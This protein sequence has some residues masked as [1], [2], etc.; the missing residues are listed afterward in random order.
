VNPNRPWLG[1]EPTKED[2]E[3]IGDRLAA[4]TAAEVLASPARGSVTALV[5][6]SLQ[7]SGT[8]LYQV[9]YNRFIETF[10]TLMEMS[11]E[12]MRART[13]TAMQL[14]ED[15]ST[16]WEQAT[17]VS[18]EASQAE[19]GMNEAPHIE[20]LSR[21]AQESLGAAI[22]IYSPVRDNLNNLIGA[23]KTAEA[24]RGAQERAQLEMV[25]QM[26]DSPCNDPDCKAHTNH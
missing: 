6:S 4:L 24:V 3:V 2:A 14:L 7:L 17:E 15:A 10:Q 13:S 20:L 5:K 9:L 19:D 23:A 18:I 16:A 12:G 8:E 21:T 25:D 26:H 22:K 1:N 11:V